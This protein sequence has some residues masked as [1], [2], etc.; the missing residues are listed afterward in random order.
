[1]PSVNPAFRTV[2]LETGL[3]TPEIK[4]SYLFTKIGL[5]SLIWFLFNDT[6][7]AFLDLQ[8]CGNL[9]SS[10]GTG[11]F[12]QISFPFEIE[13]SEV[14]LKSKSPQVHTTQP[15]MLESIGKLVASEC[16]YLFSMLLM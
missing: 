7:V 4:C 12:Q 1:M 5:N 13:G 3:D 10:G 9:D 16:M 11:T 14:H 15:C 2:S 6:F 8:R